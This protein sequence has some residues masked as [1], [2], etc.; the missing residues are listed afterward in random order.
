MCTAM[1]SS[2]RDMTT[3][4]CRPNHCITRRMG[5]GDVN[6]IQIVDPWRSGATS[7]LG[8]WPETPESWL[9]DIVNHK[10]ICS[11]SQSDNLHE[12]IHQFKLPPW[13]ILFL[14]LIEA[15]RKICLSGV[16]PWNTNEWRQWLTHE[17]SFKCAVHDCIFCP[18]LYTSVN[19]S[20]LP[21]SLRSTLPLFPF[22]YLASIRTVPFSCHLSVLSKL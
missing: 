15:L 19:A 5:V 4:L 11:P 17:L 21:T 2:S 14:D 22:G 9:A 10:M 8:D 13:Q 3:I 20:T 1:V 7:N 12:S 6:F 16:T 18:N